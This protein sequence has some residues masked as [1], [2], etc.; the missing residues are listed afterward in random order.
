MPRSIMAEGL[1]A[2]E[3]VQLL[4]VRRAPAYAASPQ[5]LPHATRADPDQISSWMPRLDRGVPVVVYCVHG[6]QVSQGCASELE[7]AG[8]D[9]YYLEGGIEYW[10]DCSKLQH[11][12]GALP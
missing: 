8:Y 1:A 2:L 7:R 10:Q 12:K 6:H 3:K 9:A 5:M 11:L 4:D